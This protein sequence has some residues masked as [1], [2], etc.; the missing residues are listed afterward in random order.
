M[1]VFAISVILLCLFVCKWNERFISLGEITVF[2]T[3]KSWIFHSHLLNKILSLIISDDDNSNKGDTGK[4]RLS[5]ASS[6]SREDNIEEEND[7]NDDKED[8][9]P[10][11]EDENG[12]K[13][14]EGDEN[15]EKDDEDK[16]DENG[17][18]DELNNYAEA[19]EEAEFQDDSSL[20]ESGKNYVILVII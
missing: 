1:T 11:K 18:N 7:G 2:F 5:L 20:F 16:V 4:F 6:C 3:W 12:D 17:E 10:D 8:K 9:T 13:D 15:G 14:D 19:L